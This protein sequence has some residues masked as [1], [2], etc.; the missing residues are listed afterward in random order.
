M[1]GLALEIDKIGYETSI[2]NSGKTIAVLPSSIDNIQ[3]AG[4][5]ELARMIVKN[6]GL[7]VSE[8][9]VGSTLSIFNYPKRDRIQ[10]AL[11]NVIIVP[12]AKEESEIMITVNKAIKEGKKVYQLETNENSKI[13][14]NISVSTNLL[15]VL[16][17][18]VS[19]D[20]I[21]QKNKKEKLSAVEL[22]RYQTSLF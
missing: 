1:G 11:S 15:D 8:Y 12:E 22:E 6:G 16:Q 21:N 13:L 17:K 10:A 9:P 20:L 2:E 14:N 7:L 19:N 3:P 4:N 18:D 5:K